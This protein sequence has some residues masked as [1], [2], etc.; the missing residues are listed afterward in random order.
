MTRCLMGRHAHAHGHAHPVPHCCFFFLSPFAVGKKKQEVKF[1]PVQ[2]LVVSGDT[3]GSR[4]DGRKIKMQFPKRCHHINC[5]SLCA[6]CKIVLHAIALSTPLYIFQ[7]AC[8]CARV[9]F[10]LAWPPCHPDCTRCKAHVA[11]FFFS[12]FFFFF[13]CYFFY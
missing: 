8:I 6:S 7:R 9:G 10:A 1:S 11:V 3:R 2:S 4:S 5:C 12:F 13:P